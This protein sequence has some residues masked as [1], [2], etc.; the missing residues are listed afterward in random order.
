MAIFIQIQPFIH[1]TLYNTSLDEIHIQE[2]FILI[3]GHEGIDSWLYVCNCCYVFAGIWYRKVAPRMVPIYLESTN[4]ILFCLILCY[5][6]HKG[7]LRVL[8]SFLLLSS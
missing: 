3:S 5:N 6:S 7:A 4:E 8:K 1:G 2:V